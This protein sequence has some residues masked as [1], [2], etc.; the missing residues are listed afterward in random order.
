MKAVGGL[1]LGS[2]TSV[3]HNG[4]D[5]FCLQVLSGPL[6]AF[7]VS[8]GAVW[9][10]LGGS[11]VSLG[12]SSVAPVRLGGGE[13]PQRSL[14]SNP[15]ISF[16]W[17][18]WEG[19]RSHSCL[20]KFRVR[21]GGS[22]PPYYRPAGW[23]Q[24]GNVPDACMCLQMSPVASGCSQRLP[25][26]FRCFQMRHQCLPDVSRCQGVSRCPDAY[27]MLAHISSCLQMP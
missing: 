21:C 9:G 26:V 17:W 25:D 2:F 10:P 24:I 1:A 19:G 3:E 23:V 22:N 18:G 27:R 11:W 12:A 8:L 4:F 6:A 20:R 7:W 15:V 14:M 16:R 5:T 13:L